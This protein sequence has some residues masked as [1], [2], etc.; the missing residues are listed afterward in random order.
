MG[1]DNPATVDDQLL[2]GFRGQCGG[3]SY[4]IGR[5]GIQQS[6]RFAG[7][8][9]H[10]CAE[11]RT[12]CRISQQPDVGCPNGNGTRRFATSNRRSQS[13]PAGHSIYPAGRL[14]GHADPQK[15]LKQ[16]AAQDAGLSD[17]RVKPT[18]LKTSPSFS[19]KGSGLPSLAPASPVAMV[20]NM[21]LHLSIPD[22]REF[23]F[24]TG[25]PP[26]LHRPFQAHFLPDSTNVLNQMLKSEGV[27]LIQMPPISSHDC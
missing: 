22:R 20:E 11:Q 7:R 13:L 4:G 5:T 10:T 6:R 17:D 16:P 19:I 2:P 12:V 25:L 18:C 15:S 1:S 27:T 21:I 8:N 23:S 24:T 3:D 14:R 9:D 26:A